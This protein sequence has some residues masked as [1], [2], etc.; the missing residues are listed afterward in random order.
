MIRHSRFVRIIVALLMAMVIFHLTTWELFVKRLM[1]DDPSCVGGDL[2]R[3]GYISGVKMC[4]QNTNDLPQQH[5]EMRDY[6]GG[7]VDIVTIGDSFS[8]GG[9]GGKNTYYQDYIA[10]IHNMSVLN[11]TQYKDLD[12]LTTISIM[13]NNGSLERMDPAFVLIECSE[14][15]CLKELPEEVDFARTMPENE[16]KRHEAM[17]Y[18]QKQTSGKDTPRFAF[19]S[20]ANVNFIK[21][22]VAYRF[23]DNAFNGQVYKAQLSKPL[24]STALADTL[25]FYAGDIKNRQRFT[26]ERIARMN[27]HLNTLSD[28]LAAKGIKLYFMPCVDKYNLYSEYI[29]GNTYPKS[30]FFEDLR[31]LPKRYAFIDTK[32]ILA[33]ELAKGEKDIFYPDDTHWSWK[34]SDRIFKSVS[35][36]DSFYIHRK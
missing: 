15:T 7:R 19:F 28:R 35:F 9:G 5:M 36:Y 32:A 24:F 18:A 27:D 16:L 11:A 30:L 14:K 17:S 31:Q 23:S 34:A 25:L 4:R 20:E 2:A 8:N 10:S 6:T 12:L 3:L 21:N 26:A 13:N 22:S 1:V 29:I 33:E